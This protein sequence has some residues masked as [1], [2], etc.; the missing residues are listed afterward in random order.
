MSYHFYMTNPYKARREDL[1]LTQPSLASVAGVS[2]HYVTRVE[3]GLY[4]V[5]SPKLATALDTP[6]STLLEEYHSWQ[7]IA[8]AQNHAPVAAGVEKYLTSVQYPRVD[9]H[10]HVAL[11]QSIVASQIGFCILLKVQPSRVINYESGDISVLPK[12]MREAYLDCGITTKQ[13][14]SIE[15]RLRGSAVR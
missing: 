1:G 2:R 15:E 13:L 4:N 3:Q 12:F 7:R 10:P 5:P 9:R 6:Q 8:R 11:R 14:S